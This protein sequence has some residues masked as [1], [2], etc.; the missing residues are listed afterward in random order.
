MKVLLTNLQNL[1]PNTDYQ[2]LSTPSANVF[3][4]NYAVLGPVHIY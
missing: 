4:E 2:M 1:V 3:E